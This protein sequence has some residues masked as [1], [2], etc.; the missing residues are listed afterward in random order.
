[1]KSKIFGACCLILLLTTGLNAQQDSPI[2]QI[3]SIPEQELAKAKTSGAEVFYSLNK[4][5]FEKDLLEVDDEILI[6]TPQGE[7]RLRITRVSRFIPGTVSYRAISQEGAVFSFTYAH[8]VLLG[9]FHKKGTQHFRFNYSAR[10][11]QNFITTQQAEELACGD[12][13]V[14]DEREIPGISKSK[15]SER[16]PVSNFFSGQEDETTIDILITYTNLAE[17]WAFQTYG[18]FG[19]STVLAESMN[20]SQTALD[21]SGIPITLRVVHSYKNDYD[22][23]FSGTDSGEILRHLTASPTYNPFNITDGKL[24]EVHDLRDQYGADLVTIY[25]RVDDTGGLA[26]RLNDPLGSPRFGFSLNRVQQTVSGFT[27]VHELGHNMGLSHSRTQEIQQADIQGGVFQESVGYQSLDDGTHTVMAYTT[28]TGGVSLSSIPV[29][30]NPDMDWEGN[31]AGISNETE[32]ANAALSLKKIKGVISNYRLTI[33]DPPFAELDLGTITVNMNRE[34][35]ATVNIP[36]VNSGSS[37]LEYSIDFTSTEGL[38]FKRGK[39]KGVKVPVQTDTLYHTSFEPEEGF[40]TSVKFAANSWRIGYN[41]FRSFGDQTQFSI[42]T[43]NPGSGNNHIRI[44]E[45]GT[46]N[47]K[48]LYSPFFGVMPYGTYRASLDVSI[49]DVPGVENE[50][51][52]ILFYEARSGNVSAGFVIDNGEY[53]VRTIDESGNGSYVATGMQATPGSYQKLE[54]EYN[55]ADEAIRYYI[56]GTVVQ[57]TGFQT[58]G[59]IPSELVVVFT[60]QVT[61]TFIDIDDFT[62]VRETNPYEWLTVTN[63]S[64]IVEPGN[65][66][67]VQLNFST[68]GVDAGVY[69]ANLIYRSNEALLPEYQIPI[70]LDVANV[71]SNEEETDK[72]LNFR[73]NQNYPNPFNPSTSISFRIPKAGPVSLKVFNLLGQEVATLVDQRMVAGEYNVEFDASGLSSGLYIY[74]LKTEGAELSRKMMLVK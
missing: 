38:V 54:V 69:N 5:I 4:E 32:I 57:E 64:G 20:M 51:F 72:A 33:T 71:V 30:S 28:Y 50:Q 62:I 40:S 55:A 19:M 58:E 37:N 49:S 65:T 24:D 47:T 8:D 10:A 9:H 15:N 35:T 53:F 36:I 29:F 59:N 13:L 39:S 23:G 73:L 42:K 25:A 44:Q 16:V 74:R 63:Q 21:N 52:D 48:I 41:F 14:F 66:V 61:G 7:E 45:D 43:T 68:I 17:G 56:G 3:N 34:E 2:Y 11:K 31:S 60:N 18:I 6:Q 67:N 22:E 70:T 1:M 26:W 46:G 12:E 27:V